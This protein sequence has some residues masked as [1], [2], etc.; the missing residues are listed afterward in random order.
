MC[1][2]GGGGTVGT[3][4]NQTSN[5]LAQPIPVPAPTPAQ[6]EQARTDQANALT[7]ARN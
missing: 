6:L 2:C 5:N 7:N 3:A 1:G 4:A